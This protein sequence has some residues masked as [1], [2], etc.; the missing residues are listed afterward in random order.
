MKK[1][2][3]FLFSTKFV[4][5]IS[6]L[7]SIALFVVVSLF[8]GSIFYDIFLVLALL[9][10]IAYL[11]KSNE[12]PEYRITWVLLV[13]IAPVFGVSLFL[14]LKSTKGT[15]K[16]KKNWQ[17]I[18]Y[19][20]S[21]ALTQQPE[22]LDNLTKVNETSKTISNYVL[23]ESNF[24]VYQNTTS[25]YF[26]NGETYF[27]NMFADLNKAKKFIFAEFFIIKPGKI[28]NEFFDIVR[29]K[30]R[31]GVEVRLIFDDFGCLDRFEDKKFFKKLE[32]HGIKVACFNKIVPSINLFAN[33][34]DHRKIVVIDGVMGYTGGLNLADEYAN[35]DSPFGYWKDTGI[36]ISGEAVFSLSVMFLNHWELSTKTKTDFTKYKITQ[37]NR[38]RAKEYVQPFGSGPLGS[39]IAKN[40]YLKLISNAKRYCYITTPYLILDYEMINALKIAAKSGV[41]VKLL[42]PGI[43]D[44]KNVFNLSRSYYKELISAGVKIFEYSAGFVHAKMM[45]VDDC[46]A[47]IGTINFDFRSLYLHYEDGVIIHNSPT[48]NAMRKDYDKTIASSHLVTLRDLKERK[49]TEKISAQILRMFAPLM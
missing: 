15:K 47:V 12:A 20:S 37:E 5:A 22:I 39:P 13:L 16:Q 43:P 38:T 28:W 21:L 35:I 40:V 17:A 25:E 8:A 49:L 4:L 23:S 46:S 33:Y 1:F 45:I 24:P 42:M 41:D 9:I 30:A 31:E 34:R 3:K 29:K 44:K 27:K 14:I 18:S 7:I 6:F 2:F 48:I 26:A 36:K 19:S 10:S 32:N 11:T